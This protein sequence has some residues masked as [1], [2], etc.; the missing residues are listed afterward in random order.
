[1]PRSL[2]A[3]LLAWVLLPLASS[4]AFDA[5]ITYNNALDTASVVQDR[6]LLGSARSIAEQIRF[7]NG[8]FQ[9]Q[10]PPA[11]LELFQS[12]QPDRIYYRVTTGAG[13]LLAGYTALARPHI[14]L[15]GESPYFFNTTMHAAPV[16]AVAL[17]QPV[18]GDPNAQPVMV[19]VAQTMHGH[20]QLADSLWMHAVRQQLLILALTMVF[21]VLGLNRGLQPLLRLRNLV[22]A[23]AP[24]TLEP[25]QTQG[26]PAEL[27]PLVDSINDYIRRLEAHARTQSVFVQNAAHQLRTPLALLNTQISFASRALDAAGR[28]E[29]LTAARLTL[30]Q[31]VRLVNQLLMLSA[32]EAFGNDAQADGSAANDMPTV[33][34]QVFESLA[35][36]ALEKNID[37]G[38]EATGT[39]R[40]VRA[41]PL[42]LREILKNLID[43]AIRYSDI[44]GVVTVRFQLSERGSCI[45][46][47]D[48]GPGIPAEFRERVFERFFRI[49]DHDSNG[50][51]LGLAIVR[52]FAAKVGATVRIATPPNGVGLA[53]TVQFA[54][55]Q[56]DVSQNLTSPS[57]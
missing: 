46:V 47:Q 44:N 7:E 23:R 56:E 32:A 15:R 52:E 54:P 4:M 41:P 38:F 20:Q 30:Q 17:L 50:S 42:A 48:D 14:G 6:L 18:I 25:V 27:A 10:I 51:G 40:P 31:T 5:W 11:A 39:P 37:L 57:G 21:I 3:N 53:V 16:R 9:N 8:L 49:D 22:N 24:G 45:T 19:E 35:H 28:M 36:Q 43:N 13:R 29:S 1:L 2:R 26:M 34:Q 55:A 33:V 12:T